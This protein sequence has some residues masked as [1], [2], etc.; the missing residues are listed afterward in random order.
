MAISFGAGVVAAQPRATHASDERRTPKPAV[1][2]RPARSGDAADEHHEMPRGR[3]SAR[4]YVFIAFVLESALIG[5]LPGVALHA[6][7]SDHDLATGIAFA[8]GAV[9]A[10]MIFRDSWR[11]IE[12]FSSRFCS[13]LMNLSMLY[14]P[15][16][17]LVYANAR[18]LAK[19]RGR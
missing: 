8:I 15:F 3:Y 16:I 12:A 13:G 7:T 4:L 19:L 18:W 1:E 5:A 10:W 2:R 17:A 6:L 11:S 14:V 9:G